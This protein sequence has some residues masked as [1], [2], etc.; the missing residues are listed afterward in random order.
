M[1]ADAGPR[2]RSGLQRRCEMPLD[3]SRPSRGSAPD[4]G[5]SY[6]SVAAL[7][8]RSG[9]RGSQRGTHSSRVHHG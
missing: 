2:E 1:V 5:G 4:P 7:G 8:S 3:D 6:P 9:I